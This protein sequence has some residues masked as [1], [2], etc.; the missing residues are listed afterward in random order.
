M[1]ILYLEGINYLNEHLSG[2]S[3]ER[4]N[5]KRA[6]VRLIFHQHIYHYS[7]KR[8]NSF[9]ISTSFMEKYLGCDRKTFNRLNEKY[10]LFQVDNK[11][12]EGS[13]RKI[14]YRDRTLRL[15][16]HFYTEHRPKKLM[17][18]CKVSGKIET[19][20]VSKR[21]VKVI[22]VGKLM[23]YSLIEVDMS[24]L[25]HYI[26]NC[27][28]PRKKVMAC[29]VYGFS[30]T[31]QFGWGMY[32]QTF[33]QSDNG[34]VTA[35]G[36]SMQNLDRDIREAALNGYYDYDISCCHFAIL[37]QNGKYPKIQDYVDNTSQRRKE[38]AEAIESEY[39]DVKRCFIAMLYGANRGKNEDKCAIAKY[40]G[41]DK[42]DPFWNHPFVSDL[43]AECIVAAKEM[44]ETDKVDFSDLSKCLTTME[45][46]M[47]AEITNMN[48]IHVPMFDGFVSSA[49]LDCEEMEK[50][51]LQEFDVKT[52][53]KRRKIDYWGQVG[54]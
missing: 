35:L 30:N 46:L 5:T 32:P 50:R 52:T 1:K 12:S 19:K 53:V 31:E 2:F 15:L 27:N 51:L 13:A 16:E 45:G 10:Q 49:A 24:A 21:Q 18:S 43:Y 33:H 17:Q 28:V 7:D 22:K 54:A 34:R 38:V 20:V 40:L 3:S 23:V 26:D 39:E 42:V 44:M 37:A 36:G 47:L 14:Q 41:A 4:V 48:L 11:W 25:K 9:A 8:G 29:Q 6:L